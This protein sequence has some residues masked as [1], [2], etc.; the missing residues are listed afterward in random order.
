[1]K[2]THSNFVY[3]LTSSE[4]APVQYGR[5]TVRKCTQDNELLRRS[6]HV[7]NGSSTWH[8]RI[9]TAQIGTTRH[10]ADRFLQIIASPPLHDRDFAPRIAKQVIHFLV[11]TEKRVRPLG[12]LEKRKLRRHLDGTFDADSHGLPRAPALTFIVHFA[13]DGRRTNSTHAISQKINKVRNCHRGFFFFTFFPR[14]RAVS[15]NCLIGAW[16]ATGLISSY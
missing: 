7:A 12:A 5:G 2:K 10:R 11:A 15:S 9:G 3:V 14:M 13:F 6:R 16:F 8:L 4:T 1:M